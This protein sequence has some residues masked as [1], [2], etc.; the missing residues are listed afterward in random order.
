M[1]SQSCGYWRRHNQT[2]ETSRSLSPQR[3]RD[4]VTCLS[5]RCLS[6]A[7]LERVLVLF[8]SFV[9]RPQLPHQY[10]IIL[11]MLVPGKTPPAT[12][13]YSVCS[14]LSPSLWILR[15]KIVACGW[16]MESIGIF[17]QNA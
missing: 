6:V 8:P 10:S 16:L 11:I 17:C 5:P 7:T 3:H 4:G 14:G 2:R 12:S 13:I 1:V 9:M 15:N